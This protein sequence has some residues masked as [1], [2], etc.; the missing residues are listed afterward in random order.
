MIQVG[1]DGM[2]WRDQDQRTQAVVPR[3]QQ[4]HVSQ[5]EPVNVSFATCYIHFSLQARL[6]AASSNLP[7][8]YG[9]IFN[10]VEALQ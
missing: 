1:N 6:H 9:D 2:G 4:D 5:S 10:M 7:M 3:W 8:L